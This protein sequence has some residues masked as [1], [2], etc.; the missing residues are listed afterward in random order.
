MPRVRRRQRDT[1]RMLSAPTRANQSFEGEYVEFTQ[2]L[3][4]LWRHRAF[5]R[6]TLVRLFSQTGD[7]TVQIG[8]ASYLLFS[9]QS[10]TSAWAVAG[11]LA[12]T[13]LPYSLVGPFVS[14]ALDRFP[15]QRISLLVDTVR[16]ICSV[17]LAM[18]I[19]NH[20][21]GAG[22]QVAL[23]LLLLVMLSLNRFS[24][25]GLSAGLA[26][27]V[28]DDEYL[29][30]SSIMP[31]IGPVGMIIGGGS[32]GAI[33][34]FAADPLGIDGANALIFGVG[35]LFFCLSVATLWRIPRAGLGPDT[36][37]H[38]GSAREVVAGL[39]D[40][41]RHLMAHRP[42]WLAMATE[43]VVRLG[44]GLLMAFVIVIYRHHFF[45]NADQLNLAIFGIG[46]WFLVSGVG[47]A[48]S[49]VISVPI[50]NHLGV[51]YCIIAM[52]VVMGV[53]Q[54][55]VGTVFWAPALVANGFIIGLAGQS[56]KVQVDTVVQA[57][58][59]DSHRG[60]VFTI[61]D[62]VYNVAT[63]LGA[64]IGALLLAPDGVNPALTIGAGVF[65]LLAALA[66]TIGSHSLGNAT[67]N[68]GTRAVSPVEVP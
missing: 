25:A 42:A 37:D 61:Y 17:V 12:L 47:F 39:V 32:G 64:V 30:A 44:Y 10:A 34:L 60:R 40:G 38:H 54:A 43:V 6:L 5:R 9:P 59:A 29:D 21:T 67:F 51:R 35:A 13:M 27:T 68:K 19:A 15:R 18:M 4:R 14:L 56:L 16:A 28:D 31:M 66:F 7:G 33:R 65:Y 52:L 55:V 36:P 48:L 57:H 58:I 53:S 1:I 24:L 8:M 23:M 22:S 11:V 3:R 46:I 2:R 50:A 20:L 62:V 26:Y 41:F 63:V 49:G 45:P